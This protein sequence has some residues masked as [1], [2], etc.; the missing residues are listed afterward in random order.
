MSANG[1][2]SNQ[3]H[4]LLEEMLLGEQVD[5]ES[6][7]YEIDEDIDL[8]NS[9]ERLQ[10]E[11]KALQKKYPKSATN[12]SQANAFDREACVCIHRALPLP[13]TL[14]GNKDFWVWITIS[15]FF[16]IV[17]WR[18]V[19]SDG[20]I[21]RSNFGTG[22][23]FDG[24]ICRLWFRAAV[25]LGEGDDPYYLAR[26]GPHRD[27]W[28]SGLIRKR[29]GSCRSLAKA[30]VRFQYPFEGSD[31]ARLDPHTNDGIRGLYR[32]I[33]ALQA[34]VEFEFLDEGEAYALLEDLARSRRHT[35]AYQNATNVTADANG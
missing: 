25:V 2:P 1:I 8:S 30:L 5:L 3:G 11:L 20:T 9:I 4:V 18:H 33:M 16:D 28:D 29:Y 27:I 26:K 7:V 23:K 34:T 12:S 35:E 13:D 19:G 32:D 14:S 31:V 22:N 21:D 17:W 10:V 15:Y 6:L 24:M